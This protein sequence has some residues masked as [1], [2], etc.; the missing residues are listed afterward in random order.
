M[1][2]QTKKIEKIFGKKVIPFISVIGI[3]I[4]TRTG[5]CRITT[6]P[7]KITLDYSFINIS[8]ANK[9]FKYNQYIEIFSKILH[10]GDIVIIEESFYGRN[11]KTFQLLSRLSAFAYTIAQLKGISA[12]RFL[13]ATTARKELGFKG[14]LKKEIIQKQFLKKLKI[15]IDDEDIIDAMILSLTGILENKTIWSS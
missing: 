2:I 11:V 12:K 3:D 15:K 14:N 13:L 9:Y 8:T 10:R 1:K 5:W 6:D 4:A 7:K